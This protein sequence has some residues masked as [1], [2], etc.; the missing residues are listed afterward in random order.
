M[1][2]TAKVQATNRRLQLGATILEA[3]AVTDTRV[4]TNRLDAFVAIHRRFVESHNNVVEAQGK[5]DT[6]G[7]QVAVAE[8][9]H[10]AVFHDLLC[11][12]IA[13]HKPRHN[14][15]AHYGVGSPA[16][17]LKKGPAEKVAA[18][19]ALVS[20]V[21]ADPDVSPKTRQV[22][23]ALRTAAQAIAV[24]LDALAPAEAEYQRL[25]STRDALAE[26]WDEALG[27]LRRGARIAADEG[28]P[29]LH[30]ILFGA[31]D[32][33]RTRKKRE[34]SSEEPPAEGKAAA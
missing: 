7:A 24:H 8:A 5:A 32:E 28:A 6:I 22:A 29:N 27:A 17:L 12:L 30:A 10:D 25:R 14:P 3:A 16:R 33:A 15:F 20:A 26:E 31:A 21:L 9:A 13:D 23:E 34:T 11:A 18:V 1:K 4:V 19:A 2:Q